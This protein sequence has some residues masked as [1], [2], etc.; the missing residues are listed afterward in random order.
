M[1]IRIHF[2]AVLLLLSFITTAECQT[3]YGSNEQVGKY[4]NVNDIKV[5]YEIYGA[6]EPLFLLHG[7]G[8]SVVICISW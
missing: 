1:K 6:G 2:V 8:G 4:A 7:N 3:S 5:H